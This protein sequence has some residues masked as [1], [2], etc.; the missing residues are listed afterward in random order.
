MLRNVNYSLALKIWCITNAILIPISIYLALG[1]RGAD[2]IKYS[3]ILSAL[4]YLAWYFYANRFSINLLKSV[5]AYRTDSV[6]A[7]NGFG[8]TILS[9]FLLLVGTGGVVIY[10]WQYHQS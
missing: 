5:E 1:S 4:N 3:L 10:L 2:W 7:T 9:I 6:E 8:A